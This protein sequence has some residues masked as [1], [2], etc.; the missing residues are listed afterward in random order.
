MLGRTAAAAGLWLGLAWSTGAL[1]QETVKIGVILPYSGP[2]ADA[3][4]QLDAG[5][6]LYIAAAWRRGRRQEDRDHPQGHRRP[7]PDVAKRL[8]Q[9]LVVRDEVDILAGFAL[10][11]EALGAADVSTEAQKLMVVMNAATSVSHREVAL[12]RAHLAHHPAGQLRASANGPAEQRRQGGLHA[13]RR[14][15][16]GHDAAKVL[17]QGLHRSRRHDRRRRQARRSPTRTSPPSSSASRTPIRRRST[18]SSPAAPSR[19]RSA[20][21]WPSVA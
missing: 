5:I 19:R 16:P 8:A 14:L 4:A 1:A 10:T 15:R 9:E 12:H 18:S 17:R 20:R 6:K 7:A 13:G 2:F 3:G 21:R 11:P